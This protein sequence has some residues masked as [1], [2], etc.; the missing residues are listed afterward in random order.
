MLGQLGAGAII[1]ILAVVVVLVGLRLLGILA[2][3]RPAAVRH[4]L[5]AV[6]QPRRWLRVFRGE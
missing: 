4:F 1:G 5:R 3:C 2:V 6:W